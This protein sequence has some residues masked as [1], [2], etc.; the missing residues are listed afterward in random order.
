MIPAWLASSDKH[1][2]LVRELT[3]EG[4]FMPSHAEFNTVCDLERAG[5]L[6]EACFF[7]GGGMTYRLTQVGWRWLNA[8]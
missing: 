6:E 8:K 3:A 1:R 4:E 5:I 2:K 7:G